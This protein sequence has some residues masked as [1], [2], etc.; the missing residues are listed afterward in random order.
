MLC[1]HRLRARPSLLDRARREAADTLSPYRFRRGE[2]GTLITPLFDITPADEDDAFL[3]SCLRP[4]IMALPPMPSICGHTTI[5]LLHGQGLRSS[6]RRY[7]EVSHARAASSLH[8]EERI[9]DFG[10]SLTK[11]K[12]F[13]LVY[14]SNGLQ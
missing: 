10:N 3:E 8:D 7:F 4:M 9:S 13:Q 1:R 5:A 12:T 2:A 6:S 14:A 11:D